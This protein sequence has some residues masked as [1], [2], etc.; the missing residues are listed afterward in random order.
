MLRTMLWAHRCSEVLYLLRICRSSDEGVEDRTRLAGVARV[1]FTGV[2]PSGSELWVSAHIIAVRLTGRRFQPKLSKET[3]RVAEH[4]FRASSFVDVSVLARKACVCFVHV[5]PS[6]RITATPPTERISTKFDTRDFH[7]NLLSDSKFCC[8]RAEVSDTLL[9]DRSTFYCC[10][11]HN[12]AV[13]A[14]LLNTEY[15]CITDIDTGLIVAFRLP[16]WLRARVTM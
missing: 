15:F 16:Q 2:W 5:R 9:D 14:L 1:A 11:R 6:A 4:F 7:E 3:T 8:N 12:F 10:R 13:E